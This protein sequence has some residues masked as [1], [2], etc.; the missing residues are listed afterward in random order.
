MKILFN[1][2]SW[3]D[4]KILRRY[5]GFAINKLVSTVGFGTAFYCS[6]W[7]EIKAADNKNDMLTY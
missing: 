5:T 4:M 2:V 1:I 7:G 3:N 6:D